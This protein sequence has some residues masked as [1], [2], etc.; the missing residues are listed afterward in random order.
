MPRCY[1]IPGFLGSTLET[2]ELRATTVWVSYNQLARGQMGKM[3]L[4]ANGEDPGAPDGIE[5]RADQP[6]PDYYGGAIS[7]LRSQLSGRGYTVTGYGW[8]FRKSVR[9]A[10]KL[11]AAQIRHDVSPADP[12]ALACHSMGGLV[13]RAAWW[14]LKQTN[15]T[16]LIR[17]VVTLS[18]P[19]SGSYTAVDVAA[20][21]HEIYDKL[22]LV[23]DYLMAF[24]GF[25]DLLPGF[26]ATNRAEMVG[27]VLT[28]PAFYELLPVLGTPE[29]AADPFRERLFDKRAWSPKTPIS[30]EWLDYARND[31]GPWIRSD[32]SSIAPE[33]MTRVAG[34][35]WGTNSALSFPPLLGRPGATG[36]PQE[37]DAQVTFESSMYEYGWGYTVVCTHKDMPLATAQSGQMAEW[38]LQEGGPP[39][40]QPEPV[41]IPGRVPPLTT[42]IPFPLPVGTGP[43]PGPCAGGVCSC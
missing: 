5:L 31:Y 7:S 22:Q 2:P 8:D 37:G 26:H 17:R 36:N 29:A 42:G 9:R 4:A 21:V 39:V 11:L 20:G 16:D 18:T 25:L 15:Q 32:A 24:Q 43:D 40:P 30:Q 28:W 33:A 34:V 41:A 12:C 19:H 35:G 14:E 1:Y 3:R 13:A 38:I 23:N 27:I 10:G 6:L